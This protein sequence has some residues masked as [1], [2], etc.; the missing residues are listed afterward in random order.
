MALNAGV[1]IINDPPDGEA[2]DVM[3]EALRQGLISEDAIDMAAT[4]ILE[5]SIVTGIFDSPSEVPFK[6][7]NSSE[8]ASAKHTELALRAAR[9][10]ITLIRNENA[11][12]PLSNEDLG[13]IAVVGPAADD[14][15]AMQASYSGT[16]PFRSS[17]LSALKKDFNVAFAPGCAFLNCSDDSGFTEAANAAADR[18]TVVVLGST[19]VTPFDS[20]IAAPE[21][22]MEGSDRADIGLP[23]LQEA[24]V[25]IF[26]SGLL[27]AQP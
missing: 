26:T 4:D 8:I 13:S 5:L 7:L 14:T 15:V 17:I 18:I 25:P 10:A 23:G 9:E 16:P 19:W 27:S 24:S 1:D 2:Q 3:M 21:T 22:E 12:L 11:T 6:R 20:G